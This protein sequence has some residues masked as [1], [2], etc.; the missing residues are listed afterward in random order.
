MNLP[1][2]TGLI[3]LVPSE[4]YLSQNYPDPF[5]EKTTIK[6]CVAYKTKV[7]LVV[8]DS[9]GRVVERLLDEEM[10]AGTYRIEFSASK[11]AGGSAKGACSLPEG[12]Y[13][14]RLQAGN[15]SATKKMSLRFCAEEAQGCQGRSY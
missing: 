4:F 15:F 13:L 10:E 8:F 5:S 11:Q 3:D 14:Y 2:K 9:E 1:H 7:K 12:V 6:L